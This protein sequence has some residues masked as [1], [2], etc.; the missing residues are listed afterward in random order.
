VRQFALASRC[1]VV[2]QWAYAPRSHPW[3]PEES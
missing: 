1:P 2:R 3:R